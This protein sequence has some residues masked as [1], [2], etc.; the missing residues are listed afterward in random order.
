[1][2]VYHTTISS[3]EGES[4]PRHLRGRSK[5]P[6]IVYRQPTS[7]PRFIHFPYRLGGFEIEASMEDSKAIPMPV[8]DEPS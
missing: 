4:T 5:Y 6:G 2:S 8:V 1:M 7:I 3:S